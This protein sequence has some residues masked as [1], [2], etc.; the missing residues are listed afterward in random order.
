MVIRGMPK[1]DN[2]TRGGGRRRHPTLGVTMGVL[3]LGV[4]MGYPGSTLPLRKQTRPGAAQAD[5]GVVRTGAPIGS[6]ENP[7]PLTQDGRHLVEVQRLILRANQRHRA[8]GA[9]KD[10]TGVVP[11]VD[12]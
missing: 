5:P 3:A 1:G 7:I 4:A 9:P 8:H 11:T 10:A 12:R 6:Q 2:T